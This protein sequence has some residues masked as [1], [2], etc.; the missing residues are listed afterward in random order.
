MRSSTL[1][2][3]TLPKRISRPSSRGWLNAKWK[4]IER[5]VG[6]SQAMEITE[7]RILSGLK[8]SIKTTK[9]LSSDQLFMRVTV[10]RQ[11]NYFWAT[12]IVII[13]NN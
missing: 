7:D 4:K 12:K 6:L 1:S 10:L 3:T 11:V 9:R 5:W 2:T 13:S 8:M